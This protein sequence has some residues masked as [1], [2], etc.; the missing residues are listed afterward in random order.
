MKLGTRAIL[1]SSLLLVLSGA[2]SLVSARPA[3]DVSPL[4]AGVTLGHIKVGPQRA[5]SACQLG[6][7]GPAA[8][9]VNYLLPP[10]DAYFTMLDPASCPTCN[11]AGIIPTTAHVALSFAYVCSIPVTV[12]VYGA[13]GSPGC[14]TPDLGNVLVAPTTY[15]VAPGVTGVYDFSFAL[16]PGACISG[17]AFLKI[18]FQSPSAGCA[19]SSRFPRLV[20]TDTPIPCTSWNIYPGGGPDDLIVDIGLPGNP[21]MWVDGDCCSVVPTLPK[22]WG[23]LKLSYR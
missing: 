13:S 16:P 18:E 17:A 11:G 9:V 10:E 1:L 5:T 7:N 4:P 2:T 8:Y 20:T 21:M 6:V 22:S 19:L 14:Y 23:G 3:T 15:T 12:G